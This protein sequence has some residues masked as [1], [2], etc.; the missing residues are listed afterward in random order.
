MSAQPTRSCLIFLNGDIPDSRPV[1]AWARRAGGVICADGGVR[2]AVRLGLE[3]DFVVG[4]MDSLPHPLPRWKRTVYW[5]DFD[6]N[7]SDFEKALRFAGHIGCPRVFV[8]GVLGGRMDHAL[9]NLA[10][11]ERYGARLDIVLV[12]RGAARLLGPGVHRF[13]LRRGTVFSVLSAPRAVVSLSGARY[14]LKNAA[15]AAGSRGL[16]NKAEGRV[17]LTVHR[18]RA[19]FMLPEG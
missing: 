5:C 7:M 6:L 8:A 2:H 4:D 15:L 19:W 12:D 17:S 18:G 13:A 16:S 9:V 14:P 1:K 3:P 11:I 10:L